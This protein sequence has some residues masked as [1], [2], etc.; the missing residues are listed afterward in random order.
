[1]KNTGLKKWQFA[2]IYSAVIAVSIVLDQ[3]SKI[4]LE[5]VLVDKDIP[6]IGRWFMLSWTLNDGAAFGMF[7]G[8][9]VFFFIITLLALP[10]FVY[11]LIR[12]Y[13]QG[14]WGQVGYSF[15]IGGLIGNAI[16]RL[17]LAQ[18]GFFSGYVRDFFYV[19]GFAVF[20]VADSFL[21]VGTIC[22]VLALMFFDKDAVFPLK[23]KAEN[24][25]E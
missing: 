11:L 5:P 6:I 12:S 21:V 18:E 25:N 4:L 7:G 3:S 22:A 13:Y 15:I 17:F 14:V 19:K 24:E 9:N 20:N 2:L 8:Q 16:D 1:M 10:M 23:K